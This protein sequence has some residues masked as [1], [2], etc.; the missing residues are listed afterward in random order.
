MQSH[1][2]S[3]FYVYADMQYA[4]N[5]GVTMTP[6]FRPQQKRMNILFLGCLHAGSH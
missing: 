5:R 6:R 2:G 4:R 1:G 3:A